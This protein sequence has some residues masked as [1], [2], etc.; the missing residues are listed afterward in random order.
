MVKEPRPGRVKTRLGRDIGMTAAA[1]WFR[2]QTASLLRRLRDPRWRLVIA[3]SPDMEGLHSRVWPAD[4]RRLPQ[5]RGDLG[6][7][8][9]R[10][11]RT[12]H[13]GHACLIGADI[14]GVRPAH[15]A[16]AFARLGEHDAVFGPAPDGGF[17]LVGLKRPARPPAGF[18]LTVR[19]STADALSDSVA[20]LPDHRIALCDTL[21]DVDTADDLTM[22]SGGSRASSGG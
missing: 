5:G 17:W 14:P 13:D 18:F 4:L 2:H 3:I 9:A 8:M 7:R 19:W 21:R 20:T 12:V 11:L 1:W 15:I 10:M 6:A 22:T 16:R